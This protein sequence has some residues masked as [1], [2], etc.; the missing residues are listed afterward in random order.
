MKHGKYVL[1][2]ENGKPLIEGNHKNKQQDGQWKYYDKDS[3][4]LTKIIYFEFGK[5]KTAGNTRS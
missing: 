1:Y 5:E 4:K 3:G 2:S